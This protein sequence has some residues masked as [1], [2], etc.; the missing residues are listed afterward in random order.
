MSL[1]FFFT[2]KSCEM[3]KKTKNSVTKS[4]SSLFHFI[5]F[6]KWSLK[7]EQ[8]NERIAFTETVNLNNEFKSSVN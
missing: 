7:T 8:S 2:V 6:G 3:G 1:F 5:S 4:Q